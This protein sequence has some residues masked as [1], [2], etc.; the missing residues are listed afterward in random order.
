M[1]E[2]DLLEQAIAH[3]EA[4]R[5]TL[6]DAVVDAVIAALSE[7]LTVLE[8]API[9]PPRTGK[10][11]PISPSHTEKTREWEEQRK[12]IT[13]L[14]ADVSEFTAMAEP[15][16]AEDV[17]AML[18]DLWARLDGAIT[19]H[20]G[21][22]D[23]HI[24][25]GVMALFGAPIASEDDPERAIRA[26]LAMQAELAAFREAWQSSLEMRI[27]INTGPVLLGEVGTTAE[28]TAIGDAVNLANRLEKAAPLGGILI[29]HNTYRHVRGVFEVQ[30]LDPIHIR[31][32]AEPVPVYLVQASKP[33]AFRVPTR[34]VEGIETRMIGRESE[35]QRLQG[36]LYAVMEGGGARVVTVVA[37]AGMGKS[38]LL[39]EFGN[40]LE[41]IPETVLYFNGRASQQMANLP[42][43]IIRDLFSFRFQIRD[44][45]PAAVARRKLEQ[46]VVALLGTDGEEKAHF[47]G[48]LIG[49]D[50]SE[51]PYLRGIIT[52][53]RQIRDRAF[54]YTA[55]LFANVTRGNPAVMFL[56]DIHWADDGSLELIEHLARG[57]SQSPLLIVA[58]A[59]ST[60][61]ER[62]PSW[63]VGESPV[64]DNPLHERLELLPL[65]GEDSRRLVR[66]IL[67]KVEEIP[68][69]L[70]ELVV[71]R[72]EGNP[73]YVEELIKVLIEDGVVV[74][75]AD[76]WWVE[77]DRLVEMRAPPTL[78]GVLQARLDRLPPQEREMLQRA[79]VVGR[80][81][82]DS[83]V[84]HICAPVDERV[85]E[86]EANNVLHA[87]GRREL[88][89]EHEGI[90]A[91]EGDRQYAFKHSILHQVTYESVLKRLRRVYHAQAAAWLIERSG[92][93]VGEYA[94]LIG[95]HYEQ[96]D[97]KPQAVAWYGR[98]GNQ[99]QDTYALQMAL[100]YYRKALAFEERWEL[101]RRAVDVLHIMG[102][103]D[104]ENAA[105]KAL[106]AAP[107]VPAGRVAY[108]WGQYHEA[109]GDYAQAQ[110]AIE[111]SL[112]ASRRQGDPVDEAQ[113]LA[114][115]G[116]IAR[117]QGDYER[118]K[119]WYSQSLAVFQDQGTHQEGA[120]QTLAQASAQA[121]D[122][123][124]AVYRQQSSFDRAR[125]CHERALALSRTSGDRIGE[126]RALSDLGLTAFYQR[127]FAEALTYH[128]QA[129]EIR[130]AIGDRAGEAMSLMNIAAASLEAGD[131]GQA[132]KYLLEVLSIQ[133]ATGNR[134]EEANVRNVLGVL[135]HQLGDLS[136]AQ[137]HLEQGLQLDQQIGD[138]AGQA[139]I[140]CNLGL[141]LRDQGDIRGAERLLADGLVLAQAQDDKYLVSYFLSHLGI[142]SL[143]TGELDKAVDRAEAALKIRTENEMR[144]L[145]TADLT[146]L[147]TAHL[148]SGDTEQALGYVKQALAIL[149]ECGGEGPEFPQRD[150]YL[151]YLV[152]AALGQEEAA[153]ATLQSAYDLVMT[154]ADRISDPG[155]RQ[156]FLEQ[157]PINR[158]IV[159][160]RTKRMPG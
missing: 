16:D 40:W 86:S 36:A 119:D 134:W 115:L 91:F 159:Q 57:C 128:Q 58:M 103:R 15:M 4:Q 111:G 126:A 143:H 94:G 80:V 5:I 112:E 71:R 81:F 51:S 8:A 95:E 44:S 27:G 85:S 121:L 10:T 109:I 21:M 125:E 100:A 118:A 97:E 31:G 133:Q 24:G 144:L 102:R 1:T 132:E 88:V 107:E 138:E 104:E 53:A 42:Y 72:A 77:M 14:F 55:Q 150:C 151:C 63:G 41:L 130:R 60:L 141:V 124:G 157:M 35:F 99:A 23:K 33:R 78:T 152:L 137:T 34:G 92:E 67:R 87:L 73:F 74:K 117:R 52:D 116:L 13:I 113:C 123:L 32:K 65:S 106:E 83:A 158:K 76:R 61:Y 37:D 149:D 146:T 7:K 59:R 64:A 90:S 56:E 68:P 154:R 3:M 70:Q 140:L 148:A 155:L 20:G 108:L 38:R 79:S 156:S 62:R 136:T 19:T 89:F 12:Q 6:G 82:W 142:V 43:S 98:A 129:L 96:A 50:F 153:R 48:Q 160:E 11:S 84:A 17:R 54:H 2:R 69:D 114:Q 46:G 25:D 30:L 145:T 39:Y 120:A 22:I 28:Y 75:G 139:Y 101:R 131:Y 66:E 122:G 26:A 29:S 127:G 49:F 93:R 135:Y 45:D 105:L 18:N 47:I 110:R 9:S 147:A